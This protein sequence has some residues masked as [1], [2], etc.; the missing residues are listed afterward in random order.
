M[1]GFVFFYLSCW[2]ISAIKWIDD[3]YCATVHH[4]IVNFVEEQS[5]F[6]SFWYLLFQFGNIVFF[7][8]K[9]GSGGARDLD[10]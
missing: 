8:D 3:A 2:V 9:W 7:C 10:H 1:I 6:I 4:L 5:T